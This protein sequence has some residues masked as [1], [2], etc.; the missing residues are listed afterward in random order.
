MTQGKTLKEAAAEKLGHAITICG[1]TVTGIDRERLDDFEIL[2]TVMVM[3]DPDGDKVEKA[4]ATMKFGPLVFG[5]KQWGEIKAQLRANNDGKL[6][7]ETV[8]TFFYAT[9]AALNEVKNS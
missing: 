2:E 9:M 5:A 4:K 1:V 3:N 6:T 7:N 8:M